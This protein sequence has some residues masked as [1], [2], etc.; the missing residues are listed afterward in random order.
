MHILEEIL[1]NLTK[2]S[3]I[4]NA[5]TK[6][7]ENLPK[8]TGEVFPDVTKSVRRFNEGEQFVDDNT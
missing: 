2:F 3:E 5:T 4:V 8:F 7:V 6:F 1:L